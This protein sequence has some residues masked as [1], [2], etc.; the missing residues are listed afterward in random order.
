MTQVR[1]VKNV[2]TNEKRVDILL[3]SISIISNEWQL[4][5][6]SRLIEFRLFLQFEFGWDAV[7]VSSIEPV[8][9]VWNS[10]CLGRCR[11]IFRGIRA[12]LFVESGKGLI[13]RASR[14]RTLFMKRTYHRVLKISLSWRTCLIHHYTFRSVLQFFSITYFIYALPP[15]AHVTFTRNVF[16]IFFTFS[17]H[18]EYVKKE[19]MVFAWVEKKFFPFDE[20][21]C[22]VC[23]RTQNKQKKFPSV[24]LSVGGL[25]LW[26]Q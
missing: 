22:F 20:C 6:R 9:R 13:A 11:D 10:G 15:M 18:T 7:R 16:M 24:W 12:H 21:S 17:S 14:R 4:W 8:K 3:D 23:L 25:L 5:M 26:T 2:A 1:T 19:S